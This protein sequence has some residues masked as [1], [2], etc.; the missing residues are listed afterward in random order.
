L[1]FGPDAAGGVSAGPTRKGGGGVEPLDRG[2][3]LELTPG[4]VPENLAPDPDGSEFE[5]MWMLPRDATRCHV[6]RSSRANPTRG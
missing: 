1:I 4:I 3:M 2:G 5:I 6:V